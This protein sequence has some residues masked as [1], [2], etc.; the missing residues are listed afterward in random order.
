M[1][2]TFI[3]WGPQAPSGI[4]AKNSP[5]TPVPRHRVAGNKSGI[6]PVYVRYKSGITPIQVQYKS[7]TSPI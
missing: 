5:K 3:V 7:N 2:R 1:L 6:T 4:Y